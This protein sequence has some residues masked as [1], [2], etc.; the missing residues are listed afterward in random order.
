MKIQYLQHAPFEGLGYIETW[1]KENHHSLSHTYF[2]EHEFQLPKTD[3]LDL[4]II[5]GGP[6][7]V[8]DED[9]YAWLK[10]EKI[11]I[12]KC[13]REQKKIL[14]V[15]LGAQLLANCLGSKISIAPHKEIGWYPVSPTIECRKVNWFYELFK[16][17]PVVF[18]WHGDQF[19]IPK[20]SIHL[21]TSEANSNQAFLYGKNVIGLQFHLEVTKYVTELMLK[22]GESDLTHGKFVQNKKEIKS[23]LVNVKK[24]NRI[25]EEILEN[26]FDVEL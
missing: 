23:G 19:E 25:L 18:H 16:N 5:M 7:G 21:I 6:M 10:E 15:C 13:I 22:N 4:L 9:K 11:F 24:C 2:F 8:H 26:L 12:K 17:N 3:D 1:I 14:G 20:E